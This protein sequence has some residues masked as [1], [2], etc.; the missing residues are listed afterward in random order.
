MIII[1]LLNK[2]FPI[3]ENKKTLMGVSLFFGI[4]I[5]LFLL[6]FEP[7]GIHRIIEDKTLVLSGFGAIT[8]SVV[9]FY[10]LI[11]PK[12]FKS[13]YDPEK[14]SVGKELLLIILQILTISFLNWYYYTR[15]EDTG[16]NHSL[17]L[18]LFITFSVGTTPTIIFVL[19]AERFLHK[20]NNLIAEKMS[21]AVEENKPQQSKDLILIQSLNKNEDLSIQK[22][23]LLC[24]K[25]EANYIN[26]FYMNNNEI[27]SVLLRNTL[28]NIEEQFEKYN[29]IKRC[30]RYYI[31]NLNRVTSID[32]NARGYKLTIPELDFNIPVSRSFPKEFFDSIK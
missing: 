28:K 8:F 4:F 16:G 30:H 19:L 9:F 3:I 1:D 13:F 14:W 11:L 23:E 6:I 27:K 29:F 32:G 5:F 18:F 12:L 20:K 15:L 26:V 31:V 25:S 2:P 7:F 21:Q 17:L 24:M 22:N 10:T